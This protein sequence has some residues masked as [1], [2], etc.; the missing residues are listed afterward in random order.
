[1]GV[2]VLL[3]ACG[4]PTLPERAPPRGDAELVLRVLGAEGE[5][6][7]PAARVA[8]LGA[9]GRQVRGKPR[10]GGLGWRTLR[11]AHVAGAGESY[12]YVRGE[13]RFRVAPGPARLLV[14]R[15]VERVPVERRLRFAPGERRALS[16]RL[17][18]AWAPDPGRLCADLHFHLGRFEGA[19]DSDL[20]ALLEAEELDWAA[21]VDWAGRAGPED[22]S[23][24]WGGWAWREGELPAL[25]GGGGLPAFAAQSWARAERACDMHLYGHRTPVRGESEHSRAAIVAAAR[26]EG[27]VVSG[28]LGHVYAEGALLGEVA[29]S[30]V[31]V[32]GRFHGLERWY[33][34]LDVGARLGA[35]AGTDTQGGAAPQLLVD[36]HA[37]PGAN[38]T[39]A[40]VAPG[41]RDREALLA[42]VAAG[43]TTVTSGPRLELRVAGAAPGGEARG[44]SGAARVELALDLPSEGGGRLLLVHDGE[45]VWSAPVEGRG[46]RH[47]L[48]LPVRASGWVA[49]RYEGAR[50]VPGGDVPLAHTSPVYLVVPGRPGW[51][52]EAAA[53]VRARLAEPEAIRTS[54]RS[55]AAERALALAWNARARALLDAR[56]RAAVEETPRARD[57]GHA[58]TEEMPRARAP[59]RRERIAEARP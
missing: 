51:D 47:A 49:A 2:G 50:R 28:A 23:R 30:E 21:L 53:R 43:R 42:A 13:A 20:R 16:V 5:G 39:C 41:E 27:G 46:P 24:F 54:G 59:R 3:A 9:D 35:V 57:R 4:G 17:P 40:R 29:A 22:R 44:S 6:E 58:P 26:R 52:P 19:H 37:P 10:A 56:E 14:T 32:L 45:E 48:E 25:P 36:Y 11:Q 31:L 15:G 7:L 34:L 18:R 33:D 1:M 8:L 12:D 55:T 38:R